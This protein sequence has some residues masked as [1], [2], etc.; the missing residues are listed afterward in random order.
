MKAGHFHDQT[1]VLITCGP[2]RLLAA[3]Q[4]EPELEATT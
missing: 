1:T 4:H 2:W 3:G